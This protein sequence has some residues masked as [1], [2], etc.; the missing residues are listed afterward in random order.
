MKNMKF[1][2]FMNYIYTVIKGFIIGA[3]MLVPGFSGGT[4]AMILGIYDKLISSLSGILTFSKNENYFIKNKFNFLFLIFFCAGSLLGM[5]IISKP[6]SNLIERYY[7]VSSFFFMGTALGGFNTVYN[8]TKEYKFNFVSIIYILLG[9]AIVYLISIIP[10]G[11]FSSSSDRSEVFMYFILIIAGLIVAIAMILPG[12]SVSYMFLL[13]GI[14]QETIDAVH[15]L[16]FPYLIPLAVGAILGVVLTTK[17]L[18]YWMEHYVKASYLIISGFVLGS[19]IQVFPG[20]PKGIE[21]ALCP[22][23]F[24]AAYFLIRLL[25]RFDPDNR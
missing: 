5:V 13:L 25:Q 4:M 7:T 17:I 16:Y 19:I 23:M 15:N 22:I 14:Y 12:I 20:I 18:E 6:L 9:A 24:L 21:W 11:F 8:K 2:G 1:L 3:S 10:E